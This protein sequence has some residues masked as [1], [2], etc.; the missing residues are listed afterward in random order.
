MAVDCET[1]TK[2]SVLNEQGECEE[3]PALMYPDALQ[4]KCELRFCLSTQI[5]NE[6]GVCEHCPEGTFPD[7]LKRTCTEISCEP[8]QKLDYKG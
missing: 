5:V 8:Y 2:Y 4:I 6:E 1:N 3:C 7:D